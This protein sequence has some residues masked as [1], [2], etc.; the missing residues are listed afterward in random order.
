MELHE[1]KERIEKLREKINE[2]NFQYFSLDNSTIEESIRDSLKKELIDLESR[3]PE[4]ITADSPTQRVGS[5]L[6]GRFQKIKHS[7]PKKSLADVF[8]AEEIKDW[9][10]RISKM[11]SDPLEF[12][13]ELKIDGLN[14]TIHYEKGV[15]MRA[16]TRG[17]GV[18]GEDVTHTVR[19]IRTVPLELNKPID[20]EV[21]GE[22][23][24]PKSSFERL[25]EIQKSK[26]EPLYAN[27]RNAAA[28]AVRQLDPQAAADR[29]LEMF[30]YQID[31][32]EESIKITT[33][34]E[35][36]KTLESLGFNV[37]SEYRKF[38]DIDAVIEYADQCHKKR[39]ALAYE[40][41]G[42][43]VKVNS[44]AQQE[45]MGF[46]AKAPRFAIAYKFPAEKVTSRI[47]SIELQVGRTGAITPVA[48]MEPVL[49][50]GSTVS[51]ATLHNEDEIRE[52]DIRI[53]DTVVIH[54]AGDIIPEVVEV[55]KDLRTGKEEQFE[56]PANCPQ[57]NSPISKKEGEAAYRC[58]NP[59]CPGIVQETISH[60][61]SKKAFNIEGMGDKVVKQLL[62]EKIITT[63]A[64][65]FFVERPQLI[66]LELFKDKRADNLLA[67]IESSKNI[68]LSRFIFALGIRYLGEQSSYDFAK[69]LLSKNANSEAFTIDNLIEITQETTPEE[70]KNIEGIGEKIGEA[71]YDW[72]STSEN[73]DYLKKLG[74]A[75]I[76]LITENLVSTGNL[77]GKS[78][79]LT[80]S[81]ESLTRD[82]AKELI[83]KNGGKV[84]SSLTK[85]TNY[86]IAGSDS[87][88]KLKKAQEQGIEVIDEAA[89]LKMIN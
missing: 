55:L 34:E 24:M 83:K 75:N 5:V 61:V 52:K 45:Q 54:K 41:D 29:N 37:C 7:V 31:R 19:T 69:F 47:L 48:V 86:L 50:A 10:E 53:G 6:S 49:V 2:L 14:I 18:E 40:I 23:F 26:G 30:F 88:S 79:V 80:G 89:F 65:I 16:I 59:H 56:F 22:V 68:D 3:F 32:I 9:L 51:R 21:S 28:G 38:C 67:A 72:F 27:P 4:L 85:D 66:T 87:G 42:L 44:K 11:T 8:S 35:T 46:T 12:V 62:Q 74:S 84:H 78:F 64:D 60:F 77:S 13:A 63:P 20:I 73:I 36:L 33:Q 81:L 58:T 76:T 43:V 39:A 15:F 82:Q 70:L 71:L 57:C 25:N 1:A 17:N